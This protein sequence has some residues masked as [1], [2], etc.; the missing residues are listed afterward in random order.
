MTPRSRRVT[1]PWLRPATGTELIGD[2]AGTD[3]SPGATPWPADTMA[4]MT[5]SSSGRDAGVAPSPSATRPQWVRSD[6][7]VLSLHDYDA[8]RCPA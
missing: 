8:N 1:P 7:V 5:A 4:L 3:Q 2:A 6:R